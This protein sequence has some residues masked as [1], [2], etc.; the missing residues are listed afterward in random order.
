MLWFKAH[1][2][3]IDMQRGDVKPSPIDTE[4][5][6]TA[7]GQHPIHEQ[8]SE[9]VSSRPT[10][11]ETCRGTCL[12]RSLTLEDPPNPFC[13]C[14]CRAVGRQSSITLALLVRLMCSLAFFLALCNTLQEQFPHK[15]P[16]FPH[17]I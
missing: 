7:E 15:H 13:S 10:C 4:A 2:E 16:L 9:S 14:G 8:T 1:F 5:M 12:K 17:K 6:H 3:K 11:V